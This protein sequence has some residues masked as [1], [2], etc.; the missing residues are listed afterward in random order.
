MIALS[1]ASRRAGGRTD[2]IESWFL[3]P[4]D[5]DVPITVPD[6]VT[7]LR[8]VPGADVHVPFFE[9]FC[10]FCPDRYIETLWAEMMPARGCE[11]AES[12]REETNHGHAYL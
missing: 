8:G 2:S 1:A 7:S 9:R 3:P 12:P 11:A 5:G 10:P 4:R 6:I